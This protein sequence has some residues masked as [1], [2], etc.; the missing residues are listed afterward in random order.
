[1]DFSLIDCLILTILI[2]LTKYY[3]VICLKL[4]KIL[5]NLLK[6]LRGGILF[7]RKRNNNLQRNFN[8]LVKIT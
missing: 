2:L 1:M 5:I 6:F 3:V 7:C 4:I 8:L